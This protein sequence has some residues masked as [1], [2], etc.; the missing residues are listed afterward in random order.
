MAS[1]EAKGI[2]SLERAY[3]VYRAKDVMTKGMVWEYMI[4]KLVVDQLGRRVVVALYLVA[5]HLHLLVYL[6]LGILAMEDNIS[7]DVYGLGKMLFRHGGIEH[8][9]LLVG[10]GIQLASH[11]LQGIDDL[12]SPPPLCAL[13]GHVL[14][15]MCQSFLA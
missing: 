11:A 14:T 4:F 3:T 6:M 5:D 9:V 1:D 10:K 7:Q 13:E 15:E 2:G 12:Q 8:G